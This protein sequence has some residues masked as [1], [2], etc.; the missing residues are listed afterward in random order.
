MILTDTDIQQLIKDHPD[1]ID[2]L[3]TTTLDSDALVQAAGVDLT[4]GEIYVPETD[5]GKLGGVNNPR[6][7][8]YLLEAGTTVIVKTA[9]RLKVPS[10][11]AAIG[12]PPARVSRDGI[13]MTNPGHIDPGFEGQLTFTL[14]NMGRQVYELKVGSRIATLLFFKLTKDPK[15][16]WQARGNK[17]SGSPVKQ[18][19]LDK[20]T[21]DFLS[22]EERAKA[23]ADESEK[24]VRRTAQIWTSFAG[25][26][27]VVVPLLTLALDTWVTGDADLTAVESRVSAIEQKIT[28]LQLADRLSDVEE[29]VEDLK[30]IVD[31][32]SEER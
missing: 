9:Q 30:T 13:L 14:I 15:A 12:F 10:G 25:A 4:I 31:Q 32:N 17:P 16:D 24:K 23:I 7:D 26:L 3:P 29:I 19:T 20:L 1:V 11:F 18:I 2:P 28:E 6:K 8:A 21:R 5:E 27:V 22:V